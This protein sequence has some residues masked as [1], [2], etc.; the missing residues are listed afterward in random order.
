MRE[1]SLVKVVR[2][3]QITLPAELRKALDLDEG[4]YLEVEVE[5]G[6]IV[7]RPKVVVDK[8]K[9]WEQLSAVLEE[10]HRKNEGVDP[11]E[12][13]EAV[14]EAVKSLRGADGSQ[15]EEPEG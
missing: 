1:M 11:R 5:G 14:R 9:A 6:N 10:V 4:D 3:G 7:L 12:V 2:N 8:D 15:D 13:E